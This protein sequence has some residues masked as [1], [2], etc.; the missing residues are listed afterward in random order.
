MSQPR[1]KWLPNSL[2]KQWLNQSLHPLQKPL[3]K[4][5]PSQ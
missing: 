4:L 1:L 5:L 3:L 2:M